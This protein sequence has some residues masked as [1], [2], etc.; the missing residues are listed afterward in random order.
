MINLMPPEYRQ[1]I[2]FSRR[3]TALIKWLIGIG[4]AAT[5]LV[6]IAGGSMF[7]LKQDSKSLQQS[8]DSTKADL[9]SSNEEET[10]K[11][12]AEISG[13]LKLVVDVLSREVLFSKL[14][15]QIGLVMPSG[16]ILQD[17]SLSRDLQGGI[18]LLVGASS[19]NTATQAQVN[20]QDQ[21]N[22]IFEKADIQSLSCEESS[23]VSGYP[24][25]ASMRALF[26]KDNNPFLL[27][28]Q[29]KDN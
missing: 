2:S 6:L 8:I 10:L 27:L 3:N 4:I 7:Y 1:A 25:Q 12:V 29:E 26:I 9:K 13:S 11:R 14:L 28:N 17:L 15:Q 18:D 19:Y 5:G 22:G 21:A 16:T 20:L 23:G 24:C